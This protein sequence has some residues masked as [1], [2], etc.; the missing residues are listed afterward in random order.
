M[1]LQRHKSWTNL[2]KTQHTFLRIYSMRK[3]EASAVKTPTTDRDEIS[4]ASPLGLPDSLWCLRSA[5][6]LLLCCQLHQHIS[7]F[8]KEG[9]G[10][11]GGSV[12]HF[13]CGKCS[14]VAG[15]ISKLF[16]LLCSFVI[17]SPTTCVVSSE[18]DLQSQRE[19]WTQ[20]KY[21]KKLDGK[22]WKYDIYTIFPVM[23]K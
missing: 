19:V 22:M 2:I 14:P 9:V 18:W 21:S 13:G 8:S 12:L 23:A 1:R 5:N 4:Q 20:I 15:R 7:F 17:F 11:G 16:L 10:E 3:S 6:L